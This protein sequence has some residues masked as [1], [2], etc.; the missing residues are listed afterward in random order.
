M[1][2]RRRRLRAARSSP[3]PCRPRPIAAPGRP[4]VTFA[5]ERL[6]DIAAAESWASTASN[7]AAGT[8]SRRRQMPYRNAVG[9]LYDSGT[10]EDNMD[11]AMRNRR[12][13]RLCGAAQARRRSAASCS[14]WAS[15]NYVESSIGAP[16]ERAEITVKPEGRVDVVIGTQP[17]GQ[18]HETSFAQVVADLL[19]SAGRDGRHHHGRH[20]HRQRR[21]RLAFR[22]LDAP[23]RDRDRQGR[24][25]HDRARQGDRRASAWRRRRTRSSSP[26][27]ASPR[28]RATARFDFLE[29]AQEA[30]AAC[31]AR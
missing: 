1:T 31:L 21:R 25:G 9:A 13:E 7:C 14:A 3:T 30:C 12:L 10:Y 8:S 11:L 4:E 22:P 23:R 16:K 24:A 19:G 26:A 2:F 18:G 5:I 27:A 17:S 6:I 29:L 20:R 28:A 15:R